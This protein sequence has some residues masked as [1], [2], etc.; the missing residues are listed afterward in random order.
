MCRFGRLFE[1]WSA[2]VTSSTA[3]ILWHLTRNSRLPYW[4]LRRLW[5]SS[6]TGAL[7]LYRPID[8]RSLNPTQLNG[9]LSEERQYNGSAVKAYN[10]AWLQCSPAPVC[11]IL[12]LHQSLVKVIWFFQV[13]VTIHQVDRAFPTLSHRRIT[14]YI[15]TKGNCS[16]SHVNHQT[17]LSPRIDKWTSGRRDST[18]F[19]RASADSLRVSDRAM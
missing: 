15:N 4:S 17:S 12:R 8:H 18:P 16:S 11:N 19:I 9:G 14:V 10:G 7:F 6:Y 3:P 5:L 2:S 13:S 1:L